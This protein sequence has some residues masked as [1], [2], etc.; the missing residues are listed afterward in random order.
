[1]CCDVF[2]GKIRKNDLIAIRQRWREEAVY[3]ALRSDSRPW[4]REVF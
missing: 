2:K 1:M 4:A 3:S